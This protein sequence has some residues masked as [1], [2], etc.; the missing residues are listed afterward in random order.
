MSKNVFEQYKCHGPCSSVDRLFSDLRP[1]FLDLF[2]KNKDIDTTWLQAGLG[3]I[4]PLSRPDCTLGLVINV[5]QDPPVI[6]SLAT[7]ENKLPTD[8]LIRHELS[9]PWRTLTVFT[10]VASTSTTYIFRIV[11]TIDYRQ[12]PPNPTWESM[13]YDARTH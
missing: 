2:F 4:Y 6:Q 13:Q 9:Y 1:I 12:S 11:I 8:G 7:G 10:R 5:K 3:R